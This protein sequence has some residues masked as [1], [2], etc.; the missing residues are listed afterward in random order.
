V[1]ARLKWLGV[2]DLLLHL[3]PGFPSSCLRSRKK[4]SVLFFSLLRAGNTIF[5]P[6]RVCKLKKSGRKHLACELMNG[7]PCLAGPQSS[8]IHSASA[9]SGGVGVTL[10]EVAAL[11]LSHS[12]APHSRE[13]GF[14]A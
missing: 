6:A 10:L 4:P 13:T 3:L 8:P 2:G 14:S 5:M 11:I 7:P 12:P 1:L 9:H